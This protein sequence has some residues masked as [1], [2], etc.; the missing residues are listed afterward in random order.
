MSDPLASVGRSRRQEPIGAVALALALILM[1][2]PLE[3]EILWMLHREGRTSL[4]RLIWF[5]CFLVV[6]IP[7]AFSW[8]RLR[9]YPGRWRHGKENTILTGSILALNVIAL[10]VA[11]WSNVI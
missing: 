9:R 4:E 7:F 6:A 2:L 11:L 3:G 1:I 5:G 8:R 10:I